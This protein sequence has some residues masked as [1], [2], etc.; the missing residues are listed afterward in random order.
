MEVLAIRWKVLL[1][2]REGYDM[3]VML[4]L[5]LETRD[6]LKE[7]SASLDSGMGS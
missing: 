3:T 1:Q 7:R 2:A 4:L 6:G 5:L